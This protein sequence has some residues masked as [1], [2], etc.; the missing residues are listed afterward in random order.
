MEIKNAKITDTFMGIEDHGIFTFLIDVDISDCGH[1]SIGNY[2]LSWTTDGKPNGDP[3][4][5]EAIYYIL[6]AIGVYSWEELIG[7]YIRVRIEG[8]GCART[9]TA[10]GNI[11][12]DRWFN[13]K[14]FFTN[15]G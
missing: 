10:I 6:R 3:R 11:L 14:E 4:G 8:C 5:V 15:T 12:E 2:E 13:I 7:K 9:V 1:C